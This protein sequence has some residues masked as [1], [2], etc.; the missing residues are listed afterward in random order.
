VIASGTLEPATA[1]N[2]V[3]LKAAALG[4][5][6]LAFGFGPAKAA[7][8]VVCLVFAHLKHSLEAECAGFGGEEK[9][10]HCHCFQ[11]LC[12]GYNGI[13]A[14]YARANVLYMMAFATNGVANGR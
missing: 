4:A 13:H 7:E 3:S 11:C 10:L 12:I 2:V 5:N 1:A 6:G 8:G 9:V 14:L